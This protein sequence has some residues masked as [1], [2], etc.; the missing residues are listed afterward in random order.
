MLT[1]KRVWA[2]FSAQIGHDWGLYIMLSYIRKYLSNVLSLPRD[3]VVRYTSL[4]VFSMWI[5]SLVIAAL[6]DY[7]IGRKFLTITQSRMIF[8]IIGKK[9]IFMLN[10]LTF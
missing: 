10:I 3:K 7:L 4:A 1:S 8:T 5:F 6:G 9:S 2:L